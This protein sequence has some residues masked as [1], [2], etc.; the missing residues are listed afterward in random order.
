[1]GAWGAAIFSDDLAADLRDEF[2]DLIAQGLSTTAATKHLVSE[3]EETLDDSDDS[4]VFWLALAATQHQL[5]R[6]TAR[7]KNKAIQIIDSGAD[8]ARYRSRRRE[9]FCRLCPES[10]HQRRHPRAA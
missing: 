10:K 3:Y 4:A 2:T 6:L 5:G 7:V 1:M 8:L 9:P